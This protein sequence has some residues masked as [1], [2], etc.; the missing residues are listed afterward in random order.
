MKNKYFGTGVALVTPFK[1][2]LSIDYSALENLL[3]YI[4]DGGVDYLVVLGTTGEAST[5]SGKEKK[6]VIEFIK[7]NNPHKL[8]FV[9]GL[10][11]N[12]TTELKSKL[13]EINF[14][15]IDAILS[16]SPYYNKPTQ[17]GIFQHYTQFAAAS[18]VPLILYNIPGRTA[19][20]VTAQTTLRLAQNANIIG[21]KEASGDFV[22][23]I[24]IIQNKP[25]DFFLTAGDDI[26]TVPIMSVGG[27]GSISAISNALPKICSDMTSYA[28][29]NEYSKA[30]IEL[31]KF[32]ALNRLLFEEGNPVGVKTLLDIL[33]ICKPYVRMPLMVGT[34]SLRSKLLA[35]YK[36]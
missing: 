32:S 26:L 8:P 30:N 2:D 1:E 5:L 15:G 18:P 9:L 7:K 28:L 24:E 16:V 25:T 31:H 35:A 11:G 10:G 12:D 22:Q 4:S 29:N 6:E 19:S 34:Q 33:G 20:N 36:K 13:S 21:V 3:A 23:C 27:V 17:E 14:D